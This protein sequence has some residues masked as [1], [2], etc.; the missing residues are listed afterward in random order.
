MSVCSDSFQALCKWRNVH[1]EDASASDANKA[2]YMLLSECAIAVLSIAAIVEFVTAI[3][4]AYAGVAC[5]APNNLYQWAFDAAITCISCPIAL[6][7]NLFNSHL[8][9]YRAC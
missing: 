3:V 5:D 9:Q 8:Q 4:F 6:Y 7:E 2:F 1:V